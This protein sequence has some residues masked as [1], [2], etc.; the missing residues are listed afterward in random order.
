M[1]IGA[2]HLLQNRSLNIMH[3][4]NAIFTEIGRNAAENVV[5]MELNVE[6]NN[7]YMHTFEQE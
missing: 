2:E 3:T 6:Q 1:P 5:K 4:N 7:L